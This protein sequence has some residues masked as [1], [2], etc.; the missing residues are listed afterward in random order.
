M[1]S[2]SLKKCFERW[3]LPRKQ[4]S[5][6]ESSSFRGGL[7]NLENCII[8]STLENQLACKGFSLF[9]GRFIAVGSQLC[10]PYLDPSE[11]G[12]LKA[13]LLIVSRR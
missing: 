6:R 4:A 1:S 7:P 10:P 13:L 12:G 2:K 3:T 9:E 5:F 11:S 8:S